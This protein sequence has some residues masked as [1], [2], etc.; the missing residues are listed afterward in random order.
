MLLA[1]FC[2]FTAF[3]I[4]SSQGL[5]INL[6]AVGSVGLA[7]AN[8]ALALGVAIIIL[9]NNGTLRKTFKNSRKFVWAVVLFQGL[10]NVLWYVALKITPIGPANFIHSMSP[11]L[12]I[13]LAG[14]LI[15]EKYSI[16]SYFSV[17]IGAVGLLFI[18][19]SDLNM[20]KE[21]NVVGMAITLLTVALVAVFSLAIKKL[22]A[23]LSYTQL[24]L[25]MSLGQFIFSSPWVLANLSAMATN[26]LPITIFALIYALPPYYLILKGYRKLKTAH[27]SLIGY[28]EPVFASIWGALFLSQAITPLL[29]LGGLL[30]LLSNYLAFKLDH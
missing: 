25:L 4:W 16:Y 22:S 10:H 26:I 2:V 27:V 18:I 19:G 7:W 3:F 17:L 23:E 30:I 14:V 13:L 29:I 28:S 9:K 5:F 6:L 8:S 11:L 1:I 20:N 24:I 12:I 15:K 21:F